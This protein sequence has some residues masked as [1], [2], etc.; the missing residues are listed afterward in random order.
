[1]EKGAGHFPR[2]KLAG[3]GRPPHDR[4]GWTRSLTKAP[5]CRDDGMYAP[6]IDGNLFIDEAFAG[7]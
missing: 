1:M 2:A 5:P 7:G 3:Q 6:E 4:A